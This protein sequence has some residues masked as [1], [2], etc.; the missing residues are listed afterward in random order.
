MDVVLLDTK[1]VSLFLTGDKRAQRYA[2]RLWGR[3]LALSFIS[4]A[5]LLQW[6]AVR[7][8]DQPSGD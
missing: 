6:A 4:V 7:K 3:K 8:W 5:E 1:M 2:S